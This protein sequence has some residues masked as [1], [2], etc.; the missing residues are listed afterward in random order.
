MLDLTSWDQ[1]LW[2]VLC[3]MYQAWGGNCKDL[4]PAPHSWVG[5]VDGTYK[6]EG[7][8][9]FPDDPAKDRFLDLLTSLEDLLNQPGNDLTPSDTDCLESLI[10][11]LRHDIGG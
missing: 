1:L 9:T 2:D 5:T 4:G 8:P 7:A 11:S 10:T 6:N 3:R